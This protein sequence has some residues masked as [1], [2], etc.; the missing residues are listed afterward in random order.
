M[1]DNTAADCLQSNLLQLAPK[2][3][4]IAEKKKL[5]EEAKKLLLLCKPSEDDEDETGDMVSAG[6]YF[7]WSSYL[8][9]IWCQMSPLSYNGP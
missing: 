7:A 8:G 5:T 9:F 1:A 6:T 3:I 2:I 4:Q